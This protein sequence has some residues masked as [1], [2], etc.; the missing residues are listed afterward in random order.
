MKITVY[1][2]SVSETE[3]LGAKIAKCLHASS[4]VTLDGDLGAGK[5]M[6]T[7]GLAKA[8]GVE[9]VVNSPTFTIMKQYKGKK[10]NINHLDVYRLDGIGLDFDLEE[11]IYGNDIS[12]IEWSNNIKE[13]LDDTP[14]KIKITV[15]DKNKRQFDIEYN[16]D[17][18]DIRGIL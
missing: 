16:E 11:Y 4:I 8:L 15:L 3:A 14:I 17:L 9:R 6:F 7:K 12:I 5:T 18:Y 2:N 1:T 13:V 10:Y